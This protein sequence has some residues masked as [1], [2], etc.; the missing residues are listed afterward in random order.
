MLKVTSFQNEKGTVDVSGSGLEPISCTGK[1]FT[2]TGQTLSGDWSDCVKDPIKIESI[3]Y[4]S[5][6]DQ[7]LDPRMA[8]QKVTGAS[9]L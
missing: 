9:F 4:C 2:K 6:Q 8:C 5:D 3:M 1:Q 7:V